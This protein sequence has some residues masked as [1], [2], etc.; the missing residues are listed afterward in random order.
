MLWVL[1]WLQFTLVHLMFKC[2]N[3]LCNRVG[4]GFFLLF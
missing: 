3:F 4:V 2:K 1:H